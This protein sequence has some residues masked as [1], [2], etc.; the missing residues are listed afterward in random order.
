MYIEIKGVNF[1]NK[2]AEM[3]LLTILQELRSTSENLKFAVAPQLGM[4]EYGFYS[5]LGL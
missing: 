5:K 4:C 1:V 3:M 2:G